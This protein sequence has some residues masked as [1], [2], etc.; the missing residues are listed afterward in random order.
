MA[1]TE[2]RGNQIVNTLYRD[3]M[4]YGYVEAFEGLGGKPW[5][6]LA[7]IAGGTA[8]AAGGYV[9][10]KKAGWWGAS[11]P[12]GTQISQPPAKAISIPRGR[13]K[14]P[15]RTSVRAPRTSPRTSV[16]A[17]GGFFK[18]VLGFLAPVQPP[19]T[20]TTPEGQ[21]VVV[22]PARTQLNWFNI[23]SIAVPAVLVGVLVMGRRR[24]R[25]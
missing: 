2:F 18:D 8:L 9:A 13:T 3:P 10:G 25:A 20:R 6:T 12:A 17:P 5:R 1:F 11:A 21:T 23:A 22:Q 15:A 24:K 16:A 4:E 14:A 19:V 7:Y